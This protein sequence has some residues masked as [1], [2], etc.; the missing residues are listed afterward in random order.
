MKI[1]EFL[2]KGYLTEGVTPEERELSSLRIKQKN[3]RCQD[4][5]EVLWVHGKKDIIL[6]SPI[7]LA[8]GIRKGLP[9]SFH[10]RP[11]GGQ[12]E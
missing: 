5:K 6:S 10:W 9:I 12:Y 1:V 11:R 8:P 2:Y 4:F 3:G 7:W